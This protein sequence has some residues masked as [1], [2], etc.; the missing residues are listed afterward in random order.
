ML[1]LLKGELRDHLLR[2]LIWLA[3][4]L[5]VALSAALGKPRRRATTIEFP[6]ALG[7]RFIAWA[8]MAMWAVLILPALDLG[9][10]WLAGFF[11]LGPLLTLWRWPETISTDDLRIHQ[12]AWCHR[13]ISILWPEVTAIE[14]SGYGDSLVVRGRHGAKIG[15][16]ASQV[17]SRQLL[18]E[19]TRRTGLPCPAF[20]AVGA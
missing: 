18:D 8:S 14:L 9:M 17:G 15:I 4:V 10:Y 16:S 5:F 12:S 19:I 2:A 7:A 13:D 6:P 20:A 1:D 11:A 3:L